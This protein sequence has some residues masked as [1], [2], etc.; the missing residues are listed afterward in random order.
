MQQRPKDVIRTTFI[1]DVIL[2]IDIVDPSCGNVYKH[3]Y[4][5]VAS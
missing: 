3:W 2:G 1:R 5:R 4:L